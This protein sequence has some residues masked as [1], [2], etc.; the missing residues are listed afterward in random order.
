M[1]NGTYTPKPSKEHL[2][3]R[4]KQ[5]TIRFWLTKLAITHHLQQTTNSWEI[6]TSAQHIAEQ[7]E[8]QWVEMGHPENT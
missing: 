7:R 2:Y 3:Q 6:H 5:P 4:R 8:N 1:N